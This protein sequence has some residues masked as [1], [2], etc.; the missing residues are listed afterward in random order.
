MEGTN[1][2]RCGERS[3][4]RVS[5]RQ[6]VLNQWPMSVPHICSS[7]SKSTIR[8]SSTLQGKARATVNMTGGDAA[9]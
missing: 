2:D 6:R 4:D 8:N 3:S 5:Q 9:R 7:G 1:R